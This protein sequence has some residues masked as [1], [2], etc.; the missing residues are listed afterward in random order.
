MQ[1]LL[2]SIQI[3]TLK[4]IYYLLI[5]NFYVYLLYVYTC[6]LNV[7]LC[8]TTAPGPEGG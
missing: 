1:T 5:F 7:C 6:C 8:T 2:T 4:S 3:K